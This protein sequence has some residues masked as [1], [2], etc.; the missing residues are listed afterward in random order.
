VRI[1][2]IATNNYD[3][4][5]FR[6]LRSIAI[7]TGI[8][9]VLLAYPVYAWLP[10]KLNVILAAWAIAFVNILIGLIIV[11][12]TY[13]KANGVFM[14]AFFGGMAVR[15]GMTLV[16]YAILLSLDF[17]SMVLTF[18]MMGFYFAYMILEIRF[19]IKVL[20]AHRGYKSPAPQRTR[21]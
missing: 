13:K 17:D 2:T 10:D 3:R 15:A 1:E 4:M 14:A 6:F 8:L 20:S 18:F 11:E 9:V 19:L 5:R 12:L 16:V 7:L 21:R